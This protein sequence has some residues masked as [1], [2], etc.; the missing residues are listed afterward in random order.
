MPPIPLP[1]LIVEITEKEWEMFIDAKAAVLPC[2]P[3]VELPSDLRD[4]ARR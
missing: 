4:S 1:H 3:F 2:I